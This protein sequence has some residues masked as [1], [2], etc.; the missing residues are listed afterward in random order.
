MQCL[1]WIFPIIAYIGAATPPPRNKSAL[2]K[3][4]FE[5]KYFDYLWESEEQK[6]EYISKNLYKPEAMLPIDVDR[7][8]DGRTFVSV[9][10][11]PGV[12][13]SLHTISDQIMNS[14]PLLVPYPNWSTWKNPKECKGI[15]GVFRIAIDKCNRL[16]V[17]DTGKIDEEYICS[18]QLLVYDLSTDRL[19]SKIPIPDS[20][21]RDKNKM[22]LLVTPI[23]ETYGKNCSQTTVYV[24]DVIGH[25]LIIW[26]EDKFIRLE[27][28]LFKP[29]EKYANFTIA[30]ES[31]YLPDGIFNQ[32]L[33]PEKFFNGE[34]YLYF[35][36]LASRS[37]YSVPAK[38]LKLNGNSNS[39]RY[40]G[41]K[42]VLSSQATAMVFSSNGTLFYG[43]TEDIAIGCW[44]LNK[45]LKSENLGIPLIDKQRLQ[46]MSG[47]KIITNP[48]RFRQ[49]LSHGKERL[50][51]MTNRIQKFY[52]GTQNSSEINYRVMSI[53]VRELVKDTVCDNV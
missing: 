34:R 38:D 13:A 1:L 14:G 45:T 33:T 43:L 39:T 2:L 25:G 23:V 37:L 22:G 52:R 32:I 20:I 3:T 7:S 10:R 6:N 36:P 12:P 53:G 44:N 51:M 17:L 9:V 41:Y 19:I 4:E 31:F 49:G 21:A 29:E 11:A 42:D 27:N 5:W 26:N 15:T 24:N 47:L 30:G 18:A 28:D 48:K 46:F 16:W 35:R 40:S 50:L 8:K